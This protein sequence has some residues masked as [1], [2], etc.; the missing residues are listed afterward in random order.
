MKH[1]YNTFYFK[2]KHMACANINGKFV[3][4]LLNLNTEAPSTCMNWFDGCN[5][6]FRSSPGGPLGC[7]R[8]FCGS[9]TA[10]PH[11]RDETL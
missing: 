1:Y 3:C 11:C 10:E 5:N 4:P 6:C 9:N 7:T 2:T 8:M